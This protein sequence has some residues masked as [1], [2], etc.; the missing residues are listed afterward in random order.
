MCVFMHG[1]SH[2]DAIMRVDIMIAVAQF[3]FVFASFNKER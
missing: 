3:G 2:T 1:G